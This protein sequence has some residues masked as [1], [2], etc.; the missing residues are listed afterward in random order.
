MR[1]TRIALTAGAALTIAAV[2][3]CGTTSIAKTTAP[4]AP[5]PTGTAAAGNQGSAPAPSPTSP[6]ANTGPLGTAYKVT[7]TDDSGNPVSYSVTLVKVDQRA[8]LGAYQS[9]VNPADHMVAARFTITGVSGQV[10]DDSNSDANV[11][12]SDT[13]EYESSYLSVTDGPNFNAGE[14]EVSPGQTVSGWVSFELPSGVTAAS[15]DWQP[16]L[17]GGAATWTLGS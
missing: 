4:S 1:M 2:A 6:P 10:S 8:G 15:V 11:I 14:F 3:A 13:T 17:E 16:G 5:A 7:T 12:G 9:L